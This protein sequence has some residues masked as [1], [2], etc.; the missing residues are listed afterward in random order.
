V[1]VYDFVGGAIIAP[2]VLRVKEN[3]TV[4]TRVVTKVAIVI[5]LGLVIIVSVGVA[6]IVIITMRCFS[7]ECLF[8]SCFLLAEKVFASFAL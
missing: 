7:R 8:I 2:L 5:A 1:P 3:I 6:I 4:G